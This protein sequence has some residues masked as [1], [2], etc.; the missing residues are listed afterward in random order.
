MELV[1]LQNFYF[2][3]FKF[4]F[5]ER[6]KKFSLKTRIIL[7]ILFTWVPLAVMSLTHAPEA[8][9]KDVSV[10]AKFLIALPFMLF[11]P[12][13]IKDDLKKIIYHFVES[14]MIKESEKEKFHSYVCSTQALKKSHIALTILWVI[15]YGSVIFVST[16]FDIPSA[17]GW[18]N[19]SFAGAWFVYISQPIYSFVQLHFIYNA[20]L[21]WRLL[22]LISKLDLQL[23]ASHGDDT[24]GLIFL[25]DSVKVAF[26][27]IMA[28]SSS[29]ATGALNFVINRHF[30]IFDLKLSAS[31][32]LLFCSFIFIFPLLFYFRPLSRIKQ[33]AILRYGTLGGR[34]LEEFEKKWLVKGEQHNETLIDSS[35]FSNVTDSASI[36]NRVSQMRV[37]PLTRGI[38][39]GFIISVLLPFVPILSLKISWEQILKQI[40]VLLM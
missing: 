23:N 36:I 3:L 12:L 22:F 10:Q 32:L 11:A 31:I 25:A 30:D 18:R 7:I 24:G 2:D 17:S 33:E 21:W 39:L 37:I 4:S 27:P 8:F 38:F 40:M 9:F 15:V 19:S 6:W 35:D 14:G 13:T 34:Q 20:I 5:L 26:I 1:N 28:F 29:I 16:H